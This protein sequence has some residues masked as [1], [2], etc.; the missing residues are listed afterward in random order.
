MFRRNDLAAPNPTLARARFFQ[1][2]VVA[3]ARIDL[4]FRRDCCPQ[5][6]AA[7]QAPAGTGARCGRL[8]KQF[9]RRFLRKPARCRRTSDA[10]AESISQADRSPSILQQLGMALLQ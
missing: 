4:S 6:K 2:T 10:L 8:P 7:A 3:A 1:Q 9:L 5:G